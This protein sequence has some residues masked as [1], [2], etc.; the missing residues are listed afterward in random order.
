MLTNKKKVVVPNT[1][2]YSLACFPRYNTTPAP[3]SNYSPVLDD[4]MT[5]GSIRIG[6][7]GLP[8]PFPRGYVNECQHFL[9]PLNADS[10]SIIMPLSLHI[11]FIYLFLCHD[12][13]TQFAE[14]DVRMNQQLIGS[15]VRC[16][17]QILLPLSR[18]LSL[19]VSIDLIKNSI[20]D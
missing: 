17:G 4:L 5:T 13:Y 15:E 7:L 2:V 11:L 3:S 20:S 16:C 1:L 8:V 14:V 10:E 6:G 18:S 12:S 9:F 19:I